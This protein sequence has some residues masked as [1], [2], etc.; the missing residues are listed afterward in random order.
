MHSTRLN[1]SPMSPLLDTVI[2][3][4]VMTFSSKVRTTSLSICASTCSG[5][6]P[7]VYL[8]SLMF[9]NSR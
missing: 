2:L 5:Q 8:S 6:F 3:V 7:V 9:F 4:L 1:F